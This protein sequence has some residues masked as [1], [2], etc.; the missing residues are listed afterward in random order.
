[1]DGKIVQNT[2]PPT[3]FPPRT[4][5]ETAPLGAERRRRGGRRSAVR[6]YRKIHGSL[7]AGT[8]SARR[9]PV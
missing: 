5:V 4:V 6:S 9:S 7:A 8:V 1:M 2:A 3:D